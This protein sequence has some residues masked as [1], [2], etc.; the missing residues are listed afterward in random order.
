MFMEGSRITCGIEQDKISSVLFIAERPPR[1]SLIIHLLR[2]QRFIL[3]TD[4]PKLLPQACLP[5]I[6]NLRQGR[7]R[8]G[9]V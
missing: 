2:E 9:E 4:D 5:L 6:L 8:P 3:T 1:L 7:S